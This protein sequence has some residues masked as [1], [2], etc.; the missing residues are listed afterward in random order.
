MTNADLDPSQGAIIAVISIAYDMDCGH[1]LAPIAVRTA[2]FEATA[3]TLPPTLSSL[4][5]NGTCGTTTAC[6]AGPT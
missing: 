5:A 6:L 1:A 3:S 2:N 4:C